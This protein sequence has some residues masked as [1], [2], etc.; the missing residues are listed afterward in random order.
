M[1]IQSVEERF[2]Q[3]QQYNSLFGF[4]YD[5]YSIKRKST[6][7]V[8]KACKN[9]KKKSLMHNGNKDTDAEDLCCEFIAIA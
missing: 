9:L 3:L 2:P 7:E 4:L 1:V 8:I 6:E 5:I